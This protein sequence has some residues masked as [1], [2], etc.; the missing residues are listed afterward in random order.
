MSIAKPIKTNLTANL[1]APYTLFCL[2]KLRSCAKPKELVFAIAHSCLRFPFGRK[3]ASLGE[4]LLF[5][6]NQFIIYPLVHI[7]Q[8]YPIR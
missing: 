8:L 1:K 2:E 6:D 7:T 5:N 3:A 4:R